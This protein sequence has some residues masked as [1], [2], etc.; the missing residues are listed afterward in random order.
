MGKTPSCL[1]SYPR[2]PRPTPLKRSLSFVAGAAVLLGLLIAAGCIP[3]QRLYIAAPS[4]LPFTTAEMNA[5]G[6]WV[7]LHPSP[8]RVIMDPHQV[9][10]FNASIRSGKA[11]VRDLT[12]L[13]PKWKGQALRKALEEPL[14][15]LRKGRLFRAGGRPPGA[16]WFGRVR[17]AMGLES[18]PEEVPVRYGFLTRFSDQRV[19][20]TLEGLYAEP[21]DFDFDELQNSGYDMG[22]PLAI[23]H[24]S[25]DGRWLYGM[26]PFSEGWFETDRVAFCDLSQLRDYEEA[27]ASAVVTRARADLFLDPGLTRFHGRARMGSRFPLKKED[28]EGTWEVLIPVRTEDG[29]CR[30][31]PGYLA[32]REAHRGFLPYTARQVYR[33]AFELL[34]APYGWGDVRE[35]QDCSRFVQAV[36]STVGVFLPR[37]SSSQSLTGKAVEPFGEALPDEVKARTLAE[38]ALPGATLLRLPGHIMLFLGTVDGRPYVIQE[39]WGYREPGPE[40]DRVRLINRVVVS[41][42]SLGTGSRRG[43][44]L[45]RIDRARIVSE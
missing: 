4:Q 19:L 7:A 16:A 17:Q 18:I 8:D 13:P 20:P 14:D 44:L 11:G 33:Q 40:G 12:A 15:G 36:Y 10:A 26:T 39:V 30:F 45:S 41:D 24:G 42:L 23:L 5:P 28:S 31:V 1:P 6:F 37:N 25:P 3:R 21:G 27:P 22:T 9:E 2:V 38:K 29:R 35:E 43:S 32:G 34:N